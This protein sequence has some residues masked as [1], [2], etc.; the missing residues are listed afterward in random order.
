[1]TSS[2]E[3]DVYTV[4]NR[5]V[6]A[7]NTVLG[8]PMVI[9]VFAFGEQAF[10]GTEEST[11]ILNDYNLSE[12]SCPVTCLSCCRGMHAEVHLITRR[13]ISSHFTSPHH[14][15]LYFAACFIDEI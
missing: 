1:M 12:H 5:S 10:I 2:S 15:Q 4:L 6:K 13:A 14:V 11:V 3:G 7:R 8:K 9:L